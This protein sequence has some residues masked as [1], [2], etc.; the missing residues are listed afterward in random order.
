MGTRILILGAGQLGSRYLQGLA[1]Y[2]TPLEIYVSDISQDVLSR[3]LSRW[4][5][6]TPQGSSHTVHMILGLQGIPSQMDLAIIATTAEN[7][8]QL[9][10]A[11]A[12]QIEVSYW[13]LEKVL[14][15][16]EDDISVIASAVRCSKGAW[17]NTPMHEWSLYKALRKVNKD[18]SPIHAR[19][20]DVRG[21]A[22]NAIHYVDLVARWSNAVPLSI[23]TSK[24]DKSWYPAERVGFFD[25]FGHLMVS[26]SDG[27]TLEV[28]SKPHDRRYRA[29]LTT[30]EVH[31][32]IFEREGFARADDGRIVRGKCEFQSELT[33]QLVEKILTI[34]ACDLPSLGQ[35]AIQHHAYIHGLLE[36]WN[37]TMHQNV[38]CIP[39]T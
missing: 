1:M 32:E 17:V 12:R 3:A 2:G 14:T 37:Q 11:L 25:V 13:V 38:R 9:V 7:R 5:E 22:S 4:N 30:T 8:A 10:N 15:Q 28:T 33:S 23:D 18:E 6:V 21:L 19:Y 26:F 29:E 24:L 27:A 39:I 35:S 36:H 20:K 16:R 31:W 34:G